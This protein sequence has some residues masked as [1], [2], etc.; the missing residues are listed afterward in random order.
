MLIIVSNY[1]PITT[2]M[3]RV[4]SIITPIKI[5]INKQ[6]RMLS[7]LK[8]HKDLPFKAILRTY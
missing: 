4:V 5:V 8:D 1:H 3:F 2:P 6:N 7:N